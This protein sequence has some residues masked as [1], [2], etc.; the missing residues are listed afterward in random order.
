MGDCGVARWFI[1]VEG[2]LCVPLLSVLPWKKS[3][4]VL[5]K[6]K[7]KASFQSGCFTLKLSHSE[8]VQSAVGPRSC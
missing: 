3:N 2:C 5:S 4:H 6:V 8:H 1:S 7:T